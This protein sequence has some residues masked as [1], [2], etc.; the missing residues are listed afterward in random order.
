LNFLRTILASPDAIEDPIFF[1]SVVTPDMLQS[2]YVQTYKLQR[3]T[4]ILEDMRNQKAASAA[5]QVTDFTEPID[6]TDYP[7]LLAKNIVL[8]SDKDI[9]PVLRN[10]VNLSKKVKSVGLLKVLHVN[11]KVTSLVVV[12][13]S[14]KQSGFKK[15]ASKCHGAEAHACDQLEFLQGL[16][17]FCEDWVE[18]LHQL[19]LKNNRRTKTIRNRDRKYKIY[20]KMGVVKWE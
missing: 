17:D 20:T 4:E 12:P 19:G 16:A 1:R 14:A 13:C 9:T 11:G 5:I 8:T 7:T 18:Q 15:Q 2:I 3:E 6:P 10:I